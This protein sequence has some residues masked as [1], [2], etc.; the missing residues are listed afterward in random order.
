MSAR[1][2]WSYT[3][4]NEA[5]RPNKRRENTMSHQ[6]NTLCMVLTRKWIHIYLD[7]KICAHDTP[8]TTHDSFKISQSHFDEE[9][10]KKKKMENYGRLFPISAR[11]RGIRITVVM[12]FFCA[13]V[14]RRKPIKIQNLINWPSVGHNAATM[15]T[16]SHANF[17]YSLQWYWFSVVYV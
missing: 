12:F 15:S 14:L 9:R 5:K 2:M 7:M 16:Y 1:N 11:A 8:S 3:G 4:K 6:S 13:L 10:N 17:Q